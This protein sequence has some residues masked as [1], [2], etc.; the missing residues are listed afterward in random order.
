MVCQG[1]LCKKS[2][3]YEGILS[4][5]CR[6]GTRELT[7]YWHFMLLTLIKMNTQHTEYS[8]SMK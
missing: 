6:D 5:V 8:S 1:L 7:K 3:F 4:E 2:G